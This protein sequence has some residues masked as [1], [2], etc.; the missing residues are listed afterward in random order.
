[1]KILSILLFFFVSTLSFSQGKFLDRNYNKTS[2]KQASYFVKN[3]KLPNGKFQ[4]TIYYMDQSP[5]VT[6]VFERRK[7]TIKNGEFN[8]YSNNGTILKS[9]TYVNGHLHDTLKEYRFGKFQ[10]EITIY[11]MGVKDGLHELYLDEYLVTRDSFVNGKKEGVQHNFYKN[12][13]SK[14]EIYYKNNQKNGPF[15]SYHLTGELFEKGFY[16]N[17]SLHG[18]YLKF[19]DNHTI[20]DSGRYANGKMDGEWTFYHDNE[21]QSA[22][23]IYDQGN[24]KTIRFWNKDGTEI[25]GDLKPIESIEMLVEGVPFKQYMNNCV[26]YPETAREF[27]DQGKVYVQAEIDENGNISKIKILRGVSKEIDHEVKNCL[28]RIESVTLPKTHNR[29]EPTI[30]R[31]PMLFRLG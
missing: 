1:M 7:D 28:R 31:F 25:L 17:D 26:T 24:L 11:N 19:F 16:K 3:K 9:A 2:K 22:L 6:A 15:K 10:R 4:R 20:K 12:G 27:G 14:S 13:T 21:Q 30:I 18:N 5:H 23:E 8:Y 29:T